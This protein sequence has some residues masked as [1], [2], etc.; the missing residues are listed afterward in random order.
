M[1]ELKPRIMVPF[2]FF[3][4]FV[5]NGLSV[6]VLRVTLQIFADTTVRQHL[7]QLRYWVKLVHFRLTFEYVIPQLVIRQP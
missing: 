5:R 4:S 2:F 6:Y 1:K 7:T 3:F